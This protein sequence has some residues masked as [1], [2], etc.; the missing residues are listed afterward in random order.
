MSYYIK[1]DGTKRT[2][3][4]ISQRIEHAFPDLV[5]KHIFVQL[6]ALGLREEFRLGETPRG[7]PYSFSEGDPFQ[8]EDVA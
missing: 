4:E 6:D 8:R 5:G 3:A 7:L 2:F 1:A